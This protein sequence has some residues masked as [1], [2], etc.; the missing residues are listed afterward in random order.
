[1][2]WEVRKQQ[3]FGLMGSEAKRATI[4]ARSPNQTFHPA[5]VHPGSVTMTVRL[6]AIRSST[7]DNQL[8]TFAHHIRMY[9]SGAG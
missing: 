5:S 8:R 3:L 6:S 4:V 7:I 1:L 2:L 9:Y